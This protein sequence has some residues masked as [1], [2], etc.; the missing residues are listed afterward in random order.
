MDKNKGTFRDIKSSPNMI[1]TK[2]AV[3]FVL[4]PSKESHHV[5][6]I[7]IEEEINQKFLYP[8]F[9]EHRIRMVYVGGY[10][11][12]Q[13]STFSKI[14]NWLGLGIQKLCRNTFSWTIFIPGL[15]IWMSFSS[16]FQR[17]IKRY[18]IVQCFPNMP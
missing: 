8:Y 9:V 1:A 7:I 17:Y 5:P 16:T 6:C 3:I 13:Q 12:H 4:L 14:K 2:I 15:G 18:K 11:V 10:F